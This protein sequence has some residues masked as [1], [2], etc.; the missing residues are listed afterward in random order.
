MRW[1]FRGMGCVGNSDV[2]FSFSFLTQKTMVKE[3]T[4]YNIFQLSLP[5]R[6]VEKIMDDILCQ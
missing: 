2:I 1:G 5:I 6:V 3:M 4:R